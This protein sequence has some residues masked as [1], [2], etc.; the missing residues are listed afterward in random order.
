MRSPSPS[1]SPQVTKAGYLAENLLHFART[2]RKAGL[3]VSP[4]RVH[5]AIDAIK[6]GGL[7]RRDDFYATLRCLFITSHD[8]QEIFDQCFHIFWRNPELLERAMQMLLPTTFLENAPKDE[9]DRALRRVSEAF[10]PEQQPHPPRDDEDDEPEIEF[11]AR[12]TVSEEDVLRHRDFEQMTSQE[13]SQALQLLRKLTLPS[14]DILTRRF[15]PDTKGRMIDGRKSLQT[16]LRLG[17]DSILLRRKARRREKSPLVIL[18]DI[19]GSMSHYSRML[20]HFIH[21]LSSARD[22]IHSFVFGT[23]LH[24]IT[25]QMRHRDVDE[26]LDAV[27]KQV[28]DWSGGTRIAATLHDFNKTWS[29]RVLGQG[30]N[31]LL[32]TDGLERES[33]QDLSLEMDRLHRSCRKLIWLNPLLRFDGFEPRAKGIQLMLPHVD[34]FR[35]AHN[36]NSLESLVDSLQSGPRHKNTFPK[37]RQISLSSNIDTTQIRN[38]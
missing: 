9:K 38:R 21:G 37:F 32:I 24:N 26:A 15:I 23:R 7:S 18:C 2:L 17:G 34:Q 28:D 13:Q 20:L 27:G 6:I 22:R 16:S 35:S 11:D 5:E 1:L 30:A 29:R 8:Q 25:R 4:S 3:P 10:A 33:D 12:M 14:E 19:S 31:V 36:I